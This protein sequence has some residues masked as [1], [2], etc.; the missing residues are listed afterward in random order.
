MLNA[1][2]TVVVVLLVC[3]CRAAFG[4]GAGDCAT[5]NGDQS[6]PVTNPVTLTADTVAV[7]GHPIAVWSKLPAEPRAAI[8]LIHGRTW[9]SRPDFDLST[10]CADLSLM[11]GLVAAGIAA[12]AADLRGYGAT[13]RDASGWLTPNRAAADV[14]G[15]MK[16]INTK[17]IGGHAR[18]HLFGW[19][20]GATIAQL[21]AQQKPTLA[22]TL[23]LFGYPVRPGYNQTPEGLTGQPP[24]QPN[25]YTN[26]V[27]DFITPDS[28]SQDSIA[29][30]ATAALRA[31]PV[32]ADWRSL[33]EWRALDG[34]KILLPTLLLEAEH[35]PLVRR[36]V[37]RRL[38][39]RLGREKGKWVVIKG[40][41]HAAF[42]ERPREKF[43]EEL[44]G[45]VLGNL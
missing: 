14:A 17:R 8:L 45:F 44:T 7:D 39:R 5:S 23:T 27:S 22:R 25:T 40:G 33:E 19:S 36:R 21:M 10:P 43:L 16:W 9:S 6:H 30:F 3:A 28:I 35:D 11:N 26:A 13:P 34:K 29:A 42:L 4:A 20:Y 32:R 18:A 41:D 38:M 24:A 1:P 37:H 15:V 31:D 12:F 2:K